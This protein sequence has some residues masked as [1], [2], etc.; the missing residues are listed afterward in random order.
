MEEDGVLEVAE[1]A[2]FEKVVSWAHDA[3]PDQNDAFA[4][5]LAEW[6]PFSG[7]VNEPM[8]PG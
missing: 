8:S 5:S 7:G 6:V 4:M 3:A 2:S 1:A